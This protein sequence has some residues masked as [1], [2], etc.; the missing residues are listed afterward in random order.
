MCHFI[1]TKNAA[2]G[3]N[4]LLLFNIFED[5]TVEVQLQKAKGLK[6]K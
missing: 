5:A 4:A 3:S 1:D 2:K 6:L